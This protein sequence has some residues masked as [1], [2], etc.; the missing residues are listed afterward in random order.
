MSEYDA[1]AEFYDTL[2]ADYEV[3]IPFYVAEARRAGSPVL[4]LACGT[5]RVAIRVAQAGVEVVGID[6]SPA[7]LERFRARLSRLPPV[8]QECITLIEADMSDFDLGAE[9]FNLI[10]CPFRA[11]L[12]LLTVEDQLAAL[13]TVR[14]HLKPGGCFALNFFHPSLTIIADSIATLGSPV[15][16]TREFTNPDTGHK[17][18]MHL[19]SQHD[20]VEQIIREY[21]ICDEIDAHGRV[22]ER[23]YK[24][25]TLRWIYR[26]EFEHLLARCGFEV[27]A[28]YGTFDRQSF[29]HG[30]GELI[31]IARKR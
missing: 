25:L 26:Y 3:D 16:R 8:V 5:G 19:T 10:Y 23:S 7:M 21:R 31:W 24:P 13:Q 6:S 11:F 17:L 12:H 29:A 2:Y 15:R 30:H 28:L 9:R 18:I 27:E 1:Y 14:H 4:E 20:V 22:V